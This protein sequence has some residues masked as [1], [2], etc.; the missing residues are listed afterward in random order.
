M[1]SKEET[2]V[3]RRTAGNSL[4]LKTFLCFFVLFRS[5]AVSWNNYELVKGGKC[6]ENSYSCITCA[7]FTNLVDEAAKANPS[8][9]KRGVA[10]DERR[11]PCRRFMVLTKTG[12]MWKEEENEENKEKWGTKTFRRPS[13]HHRIE[14][15][16]CKHAWSFPSRSGYERLRRWWLAAQMNQRGWSSVH[17][18]K[19]LVEAIFHL[20]VAL[21][22]SDVNARMQIREVLLV[23]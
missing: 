4:R 11:L 6:D 10:L 21:L 17:I 9:R 23:W 3:V 19:R 8:A 2:I 1:L 12:K 22:P 18:Q 14:R 20:E 7:F 16:L 13:K 5:T 15:Q